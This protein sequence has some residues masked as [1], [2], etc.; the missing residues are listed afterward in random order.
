M[1]ALTASSIRCN[2]SICATSETTVL[3]RTPSLDI[4]ELTRFVARFPFLLHGLA[5]KADTRTQISPSAVSD[6]RFG[7]KI[8]SKAFRNVAGVVSTV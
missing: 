3:P 8:Q 1:S 6:V 7:G 2:C 5:V 4:S